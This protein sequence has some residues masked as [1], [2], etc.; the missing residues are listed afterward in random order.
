MT[1][2]ISPSEWAEIVVA[3]QRGDKNMVELAAEYGVSVP[4]ISQGL[5]ARGISRTSALTETIDDEDA[6]AR[7]AREE[8]VQHAKKKEETYSRYNDAIAQMVMKRVIDGDQNNNL[9]DKSAEIKVLKEAQHVLGKARREMWQILRIEDLLGEDEQLPDL[10]VGEYTPE[11]LER[12]RAA[13]E[14]HY[15]D[16]LK[17][18]DEGEEES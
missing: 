15:L 8:K 9:R 5:R 12:L 18:S 13:N 17:S 3:Y 6:Q 10:N 7:K 16:D 2:K 14:E 1:V 4:N 11:E